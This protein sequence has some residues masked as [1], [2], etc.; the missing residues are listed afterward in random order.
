V[1]ETTG[2]GPGAPMEPPFRDRSDAPIVYFDLIAA[3]GIMNGAVQIE[4]A[5]RNLIPTVN[6]GVRVELVTTGRL[7]C[8]PAAAQNLIL[9]LQGSLK[10][11]DQAQEG[12][13]APKLN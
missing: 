6:G 12:A 7:R 5:G 3:N 4:L 9:A 13:A 1:T 8:S 11:L 10:M 2:G